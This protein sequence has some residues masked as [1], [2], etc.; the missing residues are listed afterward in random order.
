MASGSDSQL[1]GAMGETI[2]LY[3][4]MYRGWIP[5]N[6][7]AFVRNA[8][9]IDVI[10]IKGGRQVALSVKTSGPNS[11]TN[12]QLGGAPNTPVFN[13]HSGAG[14]EFVCFV[15]LSA[16]ESKAYDVYVVPVAEAEARV[17]EA[18]RHWRGRPKRDGSARKPGIRGIRMTGRDTEGNISAGFA[19]KWA[20]Y[21][22]GWDQLES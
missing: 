17:Q 10:A 4:L 21:R 18:D 7:N 16:R 20:V 11:G 1:V 9:N 14:A 13:R 22:D 15:A 12:F 19:D 8:R 5:A 2:V 3:E 6:V